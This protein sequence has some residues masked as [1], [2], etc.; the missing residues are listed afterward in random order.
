VLLLLAS[1]LAT[2][3]GFVGGAF[4]S[5]RTVRPLRQVATAAERILEGDLSARVPD[6]GTGLEVSQLG[7]TFNA[8]VQQLADRIERDARFA[9][10]VTHEIRS[11]LTG[12]AMAASMLEREK[13]A[14]SPAGQESL[15]IVVADLG[16]FRN[17]VEDL[18]EM[19]RTDAGAAEYTLEEVRAVTLVQR[20]IAASTRRLNSPEPLV[21]IGSQ[22][23]DALLTVDR[24]RFERVIANIFDNAAKYA[25]GV[26]HVALYR[27]GAT[28]ILDLDD[29]G[30]GVAES[31]RESI[32][33]R[34]FRGSAAHDRG[35]VQGTGIGLSL[36]RQ[37]LNAIGGSIIAL[38]APTGGAR[39]RLHLPLHEVAL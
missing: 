28:F 37:H 14:L 4:I 35:S 3:L 6:F 16:I 11:P 21:T 13:D 5:F 10:D 33:E 17:L 2:T 19:A 24:R 7:N 29:E 15:G 20:C 23:D 31:Q 30:A 25:G 18:L 32:F 1:A 38:E 27:E 26:T 9:S 8:M 34:F 22:L 36:V 12:L 39:F